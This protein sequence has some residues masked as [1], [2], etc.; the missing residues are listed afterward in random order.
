MKNMDISDLTV[1]ITSLRKLAKEI[2]DLTDD[3]PAINR[4]SKRVMASAEMMK[5]NLEGISLE[6]EQSY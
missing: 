3:F 1:K 6:I 2:H 4:N 5:L